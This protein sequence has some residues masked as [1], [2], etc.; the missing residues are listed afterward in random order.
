[1]ENFLLRMFSHIDAKYQSVK[2][3]KI[4]FNILVSFVN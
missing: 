3:I 4:L 2:T 1:M